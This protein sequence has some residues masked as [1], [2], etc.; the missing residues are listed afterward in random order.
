[1]KERKKLEIE[2]KNK[3]YLRINKLIIK[4]TIK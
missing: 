3:D 2:E 1:M 4:L